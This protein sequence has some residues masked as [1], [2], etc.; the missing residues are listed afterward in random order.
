MAEI[1]AGIQ[2]RLAALR[3]EYL[4]QLPDKIHLALRTWNDYLAGRDPSHLT[5]LHRLTHSLAGSGATFGCEAVSQAARHFEI[6]VKSVMDSGLEPSPA[7]Q[8]QA[9]TFLSALE[10]GQ[11][12]VHQPPH[13]IQTELEPDLQYLQ[14]H[15][16]ER[17]F[18]VDDDPDLTAQLDAHLRQYGYEVQIFNQLG[19]AQQAIDQ[20]PPLAIIM[21]M[22]FP[23]G[24]DAGA[25]AIQKI[26]ERR[27]KPIP[28]I[29]M[30]V[31]D[32]FSARLT[33]VRA[34]STHYFTKPLDIPRLIHTLD[35]LVSNRP[36]DPYRILI[37]DD[38]PELAH[39]YK[40]HLEG[41]DMLAWVVND[42]L[43]V[44]DA[45]HAFKADVVLMD[46]YMPIC[47]GVEITAIIRQEEE[48]AAIPVLFLSTES[49]LGLQLSALNKGG[50]SFLT[51]PIEPWHLVRAVLARAK[52]SRELKL[53]NE[54]QRTLLHELEYQKF[55]LDQHAI[56]SVTNAQGTITYAN[57]KFLEASQYSE[58]ELLG[59]N[60]RI[61]N[62]GYHSR[63]FFQE[64]WASIS[65]GKVWHG[66]V[67]NRCKYG[68][69]YWM[70][71][72]IVP[73]LD[74]DGKPYQYVSIRT[75]ISRVKQAEEALRLSEERFRRGQNY[76]N[77]GTWDW[78]IQTGELFWSE[79][80]A[81][82]FGYGVG[83]LET[84]YENFLGAT[85]PDD[86]QFVM[87]SV[88]A[89]VE[90]GA[91]YDIE[92]RVIWP[93]GRIIW[94]RETG[95]VVRDKNGKPLKMLGVVQ[96]IT[97]RKQA[98][99]EVFQARDEAERANHAKSE[100]LARMSHELRTPLNAILGFGQL[101]ESD[102]NEP[103][104]TSQL[105]NMDQILKAGWHLLDLVNEALDL[106]KIESGNIDL[107][108]EDV[109]V[110]EVLE[111]CLATLRPLAEQRGIKLP[112][113]SHDCPQY[114]V[115]V[116][117]F[118][119]KQVLLNLLS[120]AVKYNRENGNI[121]ISVD[122]TRPGRLRVN[123]T[124][125]G[126]GLTTEQQAQL[127]Q[128]FN[129]LGAEKS[130]V[131]GTGIGLVIARHMIELMGGAIGMESEPGRGSIF[132]IELKLGLHLPLKET[133]L[134]RDT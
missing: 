100:F 67:R 70:A 120:N 65:S 64:M 119:L 38:D 117:R 108:L 40:L 102:P 84:T 55:A 26:N 97:R 60:H 44:L 121:T 96:D 112:K 111:E 128:P 14:A 95:D 13:H 24:E 87:D 122:G 103:L 3:Q 83:E 21:D 114:V 31:R 105:E 109:G 58:Q 63:E 19:S 101:M 79:R 74:Q 134:P 85:H 94:V 123:V 22:M 61:V 2:E 57:Q 15:Q 56:V 66:E 106:A 104:S 129:R 41:A 73:F 48:Y 116:D 4:R 10:M 47:S 49:D 35:E 11:R 5:T 52:R 130:E 16:G 43:E 30:S 125:E 107:S 29:F 80:I 124:D 71:T 12:Q 28:V 7:Q 6:F 115:H 9:R 62:S 133:A 132:W 46:I 131:Q 93:D 92:H 39:A 20:V 50:D 17:I 25:E 91:E 98:E 90:R 32:D 45:L 110:L 81:P 88:S 113:E 23:E 8:G 72:T 99:A 54:R 51:K 27:A 126:A 68:H 89:C 78:N 42:P 76:A 82:L 77:I 53:S 86:R 75:D 18:L 1:P 59:Q 69:F 118:R 34:G 33:A 37:V 127:F 36:R